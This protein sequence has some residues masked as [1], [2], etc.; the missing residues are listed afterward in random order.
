MAQPQ[1]PPVPAEESQ[2]SPVKLVNRYQRLGSFSPR[3]CHRRPG[4]SVRQKLG[5]LC[6]PGHAEA[7]GHWAAPGGT[8]S[9]VTQLLSVSLKWERWPLC[10]VNLHV[11]TSEAQ[12]CLDFQSLHLQAKGQ[13]GEGG[14]GTIQH[15]AELPGPSGPL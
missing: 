13:V 12:T 7:E 1:F 11:V 5:V 2:E 8:L 3:L 10:L 9:C 6:V 4:C 15:Q 14:C